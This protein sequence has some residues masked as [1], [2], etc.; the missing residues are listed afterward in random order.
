MINDYLFEMSDSDLNRF[1]MIYLL[2]FRNDRE[3]FSSRKLFSS[4]KQ[5]LVTGPQRW[6]RKF[7]SLRPFYFRQ[8]AGK[9]CFLETQ[10]EFP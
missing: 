2:S 7:P 5:I 1:E 6:K 4:I 8:Q 9:A 10:V 3:K